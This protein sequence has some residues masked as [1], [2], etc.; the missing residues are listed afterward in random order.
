MRRNDKPPTQSGP[1]TVKR[2]LLLAEAEPHTSFL[3]LRGSGAVKNCPYLI[4]VKLGCPISTCGR[5]HKTTTAAAATSRPMQ[6]KKV[7]KRLLIFRLLYRDQDSRR[8]LR[9]EV[10]L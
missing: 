4:G 8:G 2:C 5:P 9:R 6:S 3:G 7:P 1:R 10:L